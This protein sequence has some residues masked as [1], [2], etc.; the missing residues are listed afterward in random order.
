MRQIVA[1]LS[2]FCLFSMA[3]TS[4]FAERMPAFDSI[5]QA[6]CQKE[7]GRAARRLFDAAVKEWGRCQRENPNCAAIDVTNREE[8]FR[9]GLVEE[10]NNLADFPVVFN[11]GSNPENA[12]DRLITIIHRQAKKIAAS[13]LPND[14]GAS[15]EACQAAL[16]IAARSYAKSDFSLRTRG[17]LDKLDKAQAS[18]ASGNTPALC[19]NP[20]KSSRLDKF[21]AR[22]AKRAT[23]H[24]SNAQIP[25][26]AGPMGTVA[27]AWAADLKVD[28]LGLVCDLYANAGNADCPDRGAIVGFTLK[29]KNSLL[30][31]GSES[32]THQLS[33]FESLP[34]QVEL[35]NCVTTGATTECDLFEA[36]SGEVLQYLPLALSTPLNPLPVRAC[37][38]IEPIADRTGSISFIGDMSTIVSLEM[39][40]TADTVVYNSQA[41]IRELPAMGC[42]ICDG[43]TLGSVGTCQGGVNDLQ[44]CVV[45]DVNPE[46]GNTSTDCRPNLAVINRVFANNPIIITTGVSELPPV[47][48][49]TQG[50]GIDCPC[51]GQGLVN[52]CMDQLCGADNRCVNEP[53]V[54]CLSDHI[55]RTGDADSLHL[56]NAVCSTNA[57]NNVVSTLTGLPGPRVAE[58]DVEI[59][60]IYENSL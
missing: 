44:P 26:T 20:R 8:Q 16:R 11:L 37:V 60:P 14:T 22:A 32:I 45:T 59:F 24:C 53:E 12:A 43:P 28:T 49:C 46:L 3:T 13:M 9:E 57:L 6:R 1:V 52:G 5:E 27:D 51:P 34:R 2:V 56:V 4:S 42:P 18:G 40:E 17:C 55:V 7:V 39:E 58:F 29:Q 21:A 33:F 10:C 41:P 25:A 15:G 23:K 50:V 48:T 31:M 54:K 19:E 30:S 47:E 36:I 38:G 35:Q